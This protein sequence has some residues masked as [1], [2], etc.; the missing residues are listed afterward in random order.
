MW[1]PYQVEILGNND[2]AF[3]YV[4]EHLYY[5]FMELIKNSLRAVME[6]YGPNNPDA[7][8]IKIIQTLDYSLTD[9]PQIVVKVTDEGEPTFLS[10]LT[11]KMVL[12]HTRLFCG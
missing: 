1:V 12:A 6:R 3:P 11:K 10:W 8:P 4:P 9:G 7:P 2:L 5:I